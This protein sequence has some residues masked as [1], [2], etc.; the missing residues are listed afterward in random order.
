M[1]SS[2]FVHV[3]RPYFQI[4]M[5]PRIQVSILSALIIR[6]VEFCPHYFPVYTHYIPLCMYTHYIIIVPMVKSCEIH[7][8][9]WW[10]QLTL[11]EWVANRT[12]FFFWAKWVDLTLFIVAASWAK[13]RCTWHMASN[14]RTK[15]GA[16]LTFS[17]QGPGSVWAKTSFHQNYGHLYIFVQQQWHPVTQGFT[18]R[19]SRVT[20]STLFQPQTPYPQIGDLA[21]L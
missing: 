20:W 17:L 12:I 7:H 10:S 1:V 14:H 15:L 13:G 8:F 6:G 2:H 4:Q 19:N 21:I 5:I 9:C 18:V 16:F 11:R 3:T